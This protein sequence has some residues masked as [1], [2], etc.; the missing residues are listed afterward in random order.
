MLQAS[1]EIL[2]EADSAFD[3]QIHEIYQNCAKDSEEKALFR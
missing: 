3:E 2:P 1:C